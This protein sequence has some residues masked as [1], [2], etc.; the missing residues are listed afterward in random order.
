MQV[1][2]N[3]IYKSVEHRVIVNSAEERL[4][5]AFFYNPKGDKEI[6]PMQELVEGSN[7]PP[8]YKKMTYDEYRMYIRKHGP[9]GKALVESLKSGYIV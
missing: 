7:R 1:L 4:S 8:R 3:A 2:S 5:M 6:K 9:R